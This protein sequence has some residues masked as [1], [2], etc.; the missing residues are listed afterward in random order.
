MEELVKL[1]NGE[2]SLVKDTIN[3]ILKVE[4]EIKKLKEY[5]DGYKT[6]LLKA[7][8]EANVLKIDT[9]ELTISRT[10]ATQRETLDSKLLKE[11]KP[12][13]Y[14]EYVKFSEVKGSIRIKIK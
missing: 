2:Y 13:V 11:E 1:E 3:T 12:D 10:V 14:D 6:T 7:M 4:E 8:E 9:P 5:Q